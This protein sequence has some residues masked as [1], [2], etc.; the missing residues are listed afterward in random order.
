VKKVFIPL[1][2]LIICAFVL[3]A[4]AGGTT[5][6]P[7]TSTAPTTTVAPTSTAPTSTAPTSTTPKPTT[8]TTTPAPTTTVPASSKNGGTLRV[9]ESALV[10]APLGA[11]WEGNLGTYNTQQWALERVMKEK[12]DGTMQPELAESWDVTST[13]DDPNVVLHLRK[14][15]KF[16]DGSDWNAQALA[17]NL[18]IYKVTNMFGSTTNYW[19][20][21]DIVDDYTLKLHYTQY[22]NTLTRSWENY[23]MVSPTAYTKNGIDWMRI[24]MVGTAAFTQ[25]DYTRDVSLNLVK[26]PVYWQQG[27]PYL[28]KVQIL[29][30]V[31]E[32]TREALMKS[33]GADFFYPTPKQV[34]RFPAP[35]FK[36]ISRN[37]GANMLVPD[38]K[39]ADS[40]WS[41]V[42]VR[43][44]ADYAI[45]KEGLNTAFGYGFGAAAYQLSSSA[46]LAF[47]PALSSQYRKFDVA[48]AKQLLTDA[49]FPT[50]FKTT[51]YVDPATFTSDMAVSIQAS[52]A[53]IGIAVDLQ[54]P[55]PAAYQIIS[56]TPPKVNSICATRLNEWS[57]F[58]TTL[59]V[60]FPRS[61]GGFYYPSCQKPG[62]QAAWDA[63][64][65]KSRATA[66]PDPTILKQIGDAFFNDCTVVP[67]TYSSSIYITT[68]KVN[69]TGLTGYG[70]PYA[71][72][73]G[74]IW[75]SK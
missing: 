73:Y 45:D 11:E 58:N 44:A 51:M 63:L 34:S 50:G 68:S 16:S 35:D 19:K 22:L 38:S 6:T 59:N 24:H 54:F 69:D 10:G 48:K 65:D 60:F 4:C 28:D 37:A 32:L 29:Y 18:N 52:L 21:W 46:T 8:T 71:W 40:P 70:T 15:V 12:L 57:N 42:K 23:F 56:T 55:Q 49:G 2:I 64:L 43:M 27:K 30:V 26:N 5:T 13:G 72:D 14:G 75:I 53:K 17:W 20:S 47:D 41:N 36:T 31:D 33:G 39:N 1:A 67:L 25:T 7:P 3:S 61:G 9:V 74:N 62:G 66:A